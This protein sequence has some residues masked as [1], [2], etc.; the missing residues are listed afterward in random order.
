MLN[1]CASRQE[2]TLHNWW[3]VSAFSP[4]TRRNTVLMCAHGTAQRGATSK[5]V[6]HLPGMPCFQGLPAQPLQRLQP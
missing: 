2:L 6:V 3:K 1:V 5:N 4:N